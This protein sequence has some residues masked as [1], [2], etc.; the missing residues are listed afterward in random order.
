LLAPGVKKPAGPV[1]RE[2]ASEQA[3]QEMT[4]IGIAINIVCYPAHLTDTPTNQ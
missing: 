2:Q 1:E 4:D 3:D